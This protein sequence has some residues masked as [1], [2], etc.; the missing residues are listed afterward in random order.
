MSAGGLSY[1]AIT[2]HGRVT[3]PSVESWGNNMNILRDPPKSIH[4]RKIDKVGDTSSITQMVE[5][6]SDRASE[7]ILVYPRGVNPSVSV[8]YNNHGNNGG[9]S[10][11]GNLAGL[12]G[13]QQAKLPYT[14]IKDGA[15]RPPVLRQEELMPLSRQPRVWTSQFSKPG[16][17]DFSKRLRNCGTAEETKEVFTNTLQANIRPTAVYKI[18]TPIQETYDI[19][20]NIQNTFNTRASSGCRTLNITQQNVQIPEKEIFTDPLHARANTNMA[21]PSKQVMFNDM[22]TERYLQNLLHSR[23]NTNMGQPSQQVMV[24]DMDTERYLQNPNNHRVDSNISSNITAFTS[25]DKVLDLPELPIQHTHIIDHVAP[26][27]QSGDGT[28]YI[29]DDIQ[30]DRVLPN[31]TATTNIMDN[32]KY[33]QQEY[34]NTIEL[35]RNI[36]SGQMH[37]NMVQRGEYNNSSRQ[38]FLIPKI[39]AGQFNNPASKPLQDRIQQIPVLQESDKQRMSRLVMESQS[40]FGAT[41]PKPRNL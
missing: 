27:S 38:A 15:F 12:N 24:N 6:S 4:T 28:T 9:Q 32:T 23:V 22:D 25:I 14:I 3:L 37:T 11:A 29:H 16:F 17:V 1:S 33:K 7:A 13:G 10:Q 31:Y 36:P 30:M 34:D 40:R 21:Q 26:Y 20:N 18:E 5:D 2:N 41:P 8:S 39:Y 19:K 35:E